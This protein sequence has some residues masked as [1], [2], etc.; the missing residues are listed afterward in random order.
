MDCAR[1]TA[2]PTASMT[3][4]YSPSGSELALAAPSLDACS[5]LAGD[6]SVTSTAAPPA[7][8]VSRHSRPMAPQPS[9]TAR[10]P[11]APPA[12]RHA[13]TALAAGSTR[14]PRSP[15][16]PAGNGRTADAGTA[17]R[18]AKPP[19]RCTPMMARRRQICRCPARHRSQLPQDSIGLM[20]TGSPAPVTP[21]NS[22]PM[23]SGGTRKPGC[24]TPCSSLPQIPAE[25]TCT[26][27]SPSAT[28]GSGTSSTSTVPGPV[29]TSAFMLV[30]AALAIERAPGRSSLPGCGCLAGQNRYAVDLDL[31]ARGKRRTYGR[32]G[33][34]RRGEI[35]GVDVVHRGEVGHSGQENPAANHVCHGGARLGQHRGEVLQRD[36]G[37]LRYGFPGHRAVP[38]RPLAGDVDEPALG[39]DAGRVGT[40]RAAAAYGTL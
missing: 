16:R 26:R 35:P 8:A 18:S 13:C 39:N 22:C 10:I 20:I 34:Q 4:S 2:E 19:G 30:P 29:K 32:S 36:L 37:L 3:M 11:A 33:R 21:V 17:T 5:R 38:Q 6:R 14:A 40:R 12:S 27:T 25:R 1:V 7:S 24:L 15:D 31:H 9:T 23:I 28:S